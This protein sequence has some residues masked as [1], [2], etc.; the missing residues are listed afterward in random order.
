M[1]VRAHV[2]V[3]GYVQGVFFRGHIHDLARQIGV[4]GWVRNLFDGRVE[5][6]FE[7]EKEKVEEM[8]KFCRQGPSGADVSGV[9]VK[10]EDYKGEFSDFYI[11]HG[12]TR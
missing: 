4:N 5:A 7:G 11:N 6:L 1:K 9:E 3:G 12:W 8:I 2:Y 10:W